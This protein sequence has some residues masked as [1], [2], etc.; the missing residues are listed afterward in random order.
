MPADRDTVCGSASAAEACPPVGDD[1]E[2]PFDA[3]ASR[4]FCLSLLFLFHT[5]TRARAHDGC[6]PGCARGAQS[7]ACFFVDVF[8]LKAWKCL[9]SDDAL[10]VWTQSGGLA[11]QSVR[12]GR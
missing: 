5:H 6:T 1:G 9:G 7:Q 8:F 4:F 11:L 3:R 2:W 10:S 12:P